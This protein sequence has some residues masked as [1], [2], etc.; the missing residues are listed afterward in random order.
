[1]LAFGCV[2]LYVSGFYPPYYNI[3]YCFY[4]I[5]AFGANI[6][7]IVFPYVINYVYGVLV[8][9]R[10]ACS[11]TCLASM[12]SADSFVSASVTTIISLPFVVV[13]WGLVTSATF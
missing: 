8:V 6:L 7:L 4:L 10:V 11:S 1:M 13:V 3:N 2:V 9:L 5:F 12:S